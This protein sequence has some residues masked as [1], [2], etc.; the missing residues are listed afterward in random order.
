ME[1]LVFENLIVIVFAV[2]GIICAK[3][4]YCWLFL[5]IGLILNFVTK[6]SGYQLMINAGFFLVAV[7]DMLPAFVYTIVAAIIITVRRRITNRE[8]E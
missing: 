2:I 3:A 4:N 1:W 8:E 7:I 5:C 6:W